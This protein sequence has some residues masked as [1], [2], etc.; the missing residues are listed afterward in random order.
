M[1]SRYFSKTVVKW[2]DLHKRM[3][4]WRETKDPY[5]IWLSEVML[6]QTRVSQG[7]PYYLKFIEAF[8]TVKHLAKAP[9]QSVLRLWQGLGY[10][11]RARNLHKC[12][13]VVV[14]EYKG[15]FP[16]SFEQLKKL[17]GIGDYTAAAIASICFNEKVAVVDGNVFRVLSRIFGIATPSN[18]PEGKKQFFELANQLIQ[19]SEPE[20][21][22]Q[23]I[24]E[25]GALHCTPK[26]PK[27]DDCPF[28]KACIAYKTSQQLF[29]P[30][31]NRLKRIRKRYFYYL[32][33]RKGNSL[34]M[35]KR[36]G[37]DI[38]HGLYDFTLIEKNRS[39]NA[40]KIL[41]EQG[42][43]SSFT[44]TSISP[45][46]KHVLS[47]QIIYARFIV[48]EA[49]SISAVNQGHAF[50]TTKKIAQLPKPVLISRFLNDFAFL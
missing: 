36:E 31:K 48:L 41:A 43:G 4:P 25:F 47:H 26:N 34:L 2:Y 6:Q 30:V 10:Y 9:E 14:A 50:Y 27:C 16:G 12:A 29:Y 32:V 33:F 45:L 22:N 23:S 42:I 21:F 49:K 17:P 37:K 3:L 40:E 46:Y 1:D 38:W 19:K 13:K 18:S 8:P 28:S 39:T 20:I 5:K 35:K 44:T 24:M 15:E 7:L 11:S